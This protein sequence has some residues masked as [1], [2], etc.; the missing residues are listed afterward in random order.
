MKRLVMIT[1]TIITLLTLF[2]SCD[3][4]KSITAETVVLSQ[5]TITLTE[6]ETATITYT[7]LPNNAEFSLSWSSL[8]TSVATVNNGRITAIG[9]GQTNIVVSDTNGASAVCSVTVK[10]KSAYERLT[11]DERDFVDTLLRGINSFKNP[12]SVYIEEIQYTVS[13]ESWDILGKWQVYLTAQNGFGGNSAGLYCLS[14]HGSIS[15]AP[16]QW[17]PIGDTKYDIDKINSAIQ[18]KLN[19]S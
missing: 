6:G 2:T 15:K 7:V 8:N 12:S 10:Q 18:E 17:K 11:A 5:N 1:I 13:S 3:T 14:E 9:V 16:L 19:K 4:T